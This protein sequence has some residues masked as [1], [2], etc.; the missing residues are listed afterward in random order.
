MDRIGRYKIVRE[1]GRGA[2]GVVYHAIDP[3]IG[4]PVAIKTIQL[5]QGR[6]PE[7]VERMR[8]RLFREARSAGML[9]HPGIVTIYDVEQQGDL[10]YIAMEYVDGPTLDHVMNEPGVMSPEHMF[11][12][13]GQTSVALDYA[14]SRGIVH[15]DIKP[16]NIMIAKDGTTKI[17]DFGIAKINTSEHLTVT[18]AIVGTPHYMSPEQVQGQTVDGRSD[19]FSLAVIAYELMT[20]EKPFTGEHLTTVVYKIVAEEASLPHRLN[21]TLSAAIEGV[22]RKGLSKHADGRFRTCQEFMESLEKA[23]AATKGWK[24]MP[25]GGLL[26]EPTVADAAAPGMQTRLPPA[27]SPR[28]SETTATATHKKKGFVPFLIAVLFVAGMLAG[29]GWQAAPWLVPGAKSNPQPAGDQSQAQQQPPPE[30]P[31]QQP[32]ATPAGDA[33]PS[34]VGPAAPPVRAEVPPSAPPPVETKPAEETPKRAI[35]EPAKPEETAP[36]LRSTAS[37]DSPPAQV[38]RPGP[39]Q[40]VMV[41]S[42]PGGATATL[43][44]NPAWACKTPCTLQCSPGRHTLAITMPGFQIERRDITVGS[45]PVEMPPVFLRAIGGTLMLS[46]EPRGASITIDGRQIPEVTPAQISLTP[47]TYTV[48][49]EK[50]GVHASER[51]EIKSGINYS[52][53]ILRQ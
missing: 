3:N 49:I 13:L 45:G 36:A 31:A 37:K 25:R 1:L 29:I 26:N 39:P 38:R 52:K 35:E 51:I 44:G 6:K 8:E 48:A 50:D 21:C 30:V 15:R 34:P 42:S 47:G 32:A 40:E 2:M 16:A 28:R 23:C 27:R 33:K 10:A 12:I 11:S 19:Q 41:V 14:H 22:L 20:G 24:L 46:S 5:G 17:T 7:E 18:G 9:S 4:R 53:I 43:D